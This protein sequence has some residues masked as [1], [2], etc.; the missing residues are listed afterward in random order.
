MCGCCAEARYSTDAL[1]WCESCHGHS[2]PVKVDPATVVE[3]ASMLRRYRE[4]ADLMFRTNNQ[5]RKSA[6]EHLRVELSE[7]LR[8]GTHCPVCD[9][10]VKIY[11]R[12]LNSGMARSLIAMYR[13]AGT[14]WANVTEVTDRRSREEGKL[15]YWGLAEEFPKGRD[16]GGRA[17]YWRVT[18]KGALFAQGLTTVPRY[19]EVRNGSCLRLFGDEITIGAALGDKYNYDEM[20]RGI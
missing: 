15:A 1:C 17:G 5:L 14:T 16:D 18:R 6:T 9:Q 3:W 11:K 8:A 20:M 12:K 7:K 10:Y 19:A 2:I 13:A 4:Y